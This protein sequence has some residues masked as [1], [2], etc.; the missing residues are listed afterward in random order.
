MAA[1]NR[2][3]FIFCACRISCNISTKIKNVNKKIYNHKKN[4]SLTTNNQPD[5]YRVPRNEFLLGQRYGLQPEEAQVN[6]MFT[7]NER[8]GTFSFSNELEFT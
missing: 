2:S 5:D 3:I 8:L 6:G 4:R 1:T 7:I